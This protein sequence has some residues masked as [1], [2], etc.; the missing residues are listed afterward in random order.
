MI[1]NLDFYIR[2][3]ASAG[4]DIIS[5][6]AET[7]PHLNLTDEVDI[8]LIMTVNPG[9]GGQAFIENMIQKLTN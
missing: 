4:A 8:A 5:V 9:F 7:C 3:F 2:D 1:E 6:H